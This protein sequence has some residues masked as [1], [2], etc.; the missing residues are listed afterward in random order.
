MNS[1]Q[2]INNTLTVLRYKSFKKRSR[3]C[4][5]QQNANNITT[6]STQNEE[7][8]VHNVYY[9]Y[10]NT[11]SKIIKRTSW[12]LFINR[13]DRQTIWRVNYSKVL[14]KRLR[15]NVVQFVQHRLSS[16]LSWR[17]RCTNLLLRQHFQSRAGE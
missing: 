14:T 1:S 6:A 5:K 16:D 2:K 4:F 10:Y 9:L 3:E 11:T 17:R 7:L 15:V 13:F 12:Y 8:W